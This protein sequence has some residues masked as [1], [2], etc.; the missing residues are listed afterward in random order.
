MFRT[1]QATAS[2]FILAICFPP[3]TPFKSC[4]YCFGVGDGF[5]GSK[6]STTYFTGGGSSL[7]CFPTT[8][9]MRSNYFFVTHS[10]QKCSFN[11]WLLACWRYRAG[12]IV[13]DDS[14]HRELGRYGGIRAR[15]HTY[16]NLHPKSN[17]LN[18][19]IVKNT[20]SFRKLS[21]DDLVRGQ[22]HL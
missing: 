11:T 4:T 20:N 13:H 16:T 17:R 5:S 14:Y 9:A 7:I 15:F 3:A 6:M 18:S 8:H 10:I 12:I 22:V 21:L 19:K 2:F 1:G